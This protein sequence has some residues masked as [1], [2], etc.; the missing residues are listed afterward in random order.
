[1]QYFIF[2]TALFLCTNL[3][4]EDSKE[5]S[6]TP[7][8]FAIV[9]LETTG[10]NPNYNEIIDIGLILIDE[11][12]NEI[13]RFNSKILPLHPERINPEARKIN[14]FDLILWKKENALTSEEATKKLIDFLSNFK[15]K[16]YFI[17]FNSWF[18]S[19]FLSNLF[20]TYDY[21][22]DNWFDYK[23]FDIPSMALACG[24]FPEGENFNDDLAK[25][26]NV[27]PET[28]NPL[29]H[30]GESGVNYNYAILKSLQKKKCFF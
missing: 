10:L 15:R 24:Y 18:D 1:M 6:Q 16:P 27:T 8:L 23:V 21:R 14:G 26:L 25:L 7:T 9:D 5:T 3:L 2:L 11:D 30:T 22:F 17:A 4:S 29:V 19:A 28:K 12:M 13:G 20:R